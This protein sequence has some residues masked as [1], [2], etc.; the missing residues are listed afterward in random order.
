[1][2]RRNPAML[3]V[4]CALLLVGLVPGAVSG[5]SSQSASLVGKV[6][7][8]SGGA[9][10]GVTVIVKSPQLQ[11][12]QLTAVTGVDGDYRVLE[13]PPGIFS[14]AFELSGFQTQLRSDVHLTV[15]LAGKVDVVMKIG[16]LS[17]TIQVSGQS[18]VV[19]TVNVTGQTTLMQDQLRTI[20]MGGT[21]QEMLPLAAGV[22]MQSKPDVGDSN[23][24]ARSAII[25]YGVVLQPTLDV[26]GI[27]TVTDHAA[28]TAVY[29][30]TFSLE[31]VQFKTSGNNAD[32]G[33]PGVAQV[34]VLK[35]GSNTFHGSARGSY[36]NPKWQGNNIT[37]ALAAQGI[38]NTNPIV[39][40]GFYDDI[41][42]LGG[43]II[44]DK[45]WFY[46]AYSNQAVTQG[47]VGFVLAPN[48]DGC[49]LVTCGGTT[50]ATVHTD[51]PGYS[52]KVSYQLNS[53]TKLI[54]SKMYAVKHLSVN[55]GSPTTPLPSTR[56]QRQPQSAWKG[57]MQSA[58]SA[59]LLFNGIFGY[60]GYHVNYIDQPDFNTVGFPNGTDVK[61]NP[62]SRETS[63]ALNYGPAI[64][65]E[66]RP[67]N[68]YE[69][70]ASVSYIPERTFL[71][72]THQF[73]FGTTNDWENAGTRI[74]QDKVSGN[75]QL[76]FARGVPSQ[77]VVY[78]YPFAT[79]TNNLFSQAVYATDVMAIKRVTLNFGVRWERYHNF[80]P[81]QTRESGQF[82][83]LFPAKTYPK[84][85]VLTWI[86]TVPRAG[87][88][89]DVM[90][91][92]KTVIKGSFGLFG[93]TMGDLYSNAFNPNAAATQT[94]AWTGPCVT[95]EFRNN[96]FNNTSCDVTS[97]FLASLPSRTPIAAT[98]GLNSITNPDLK[99]NKTFEYTARM[100][101]QLIANAAISVGYVYHRVENLYGNLQYLR[102][103]ATWIPA[104]PTTPFLDENGNPVT[105]YTYPASQVGAAFNT[106]QASNA[107][108]DRADTF[109]SFEVAA[110]KRFSKK[111][112]GTTS[113]WT[114]KNHQ[115]I[116]TGTTNGNNPQSP[117]DDR[118]PLIQTWDWEARGNVT[119]NLPLGLFTS[120]SYRAQSGQAGQ[121]TQAFTAPAT[122]LRQGS[123]TL[124]MG[125]FG[126]L[127]APALQILALKVAKTLSVG[128]GRRLELTFQ[129]FNALNASG[130][131]GVNYLT[132]TQFG[133]VTGITSARVARIGAG[134]TF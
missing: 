129:V 63:N 104:V 111:W 75:Y 121:R 124:R 66:D 8:E 126:D 4:G 86:D 74:L 69:M 102:P 22:S 18:P 49:W 39:D 36:E 50:P 108:P 26:E 113:F 40:P 110:T 33:F 41:L 28:D 42:D 82:N 99:Q 30:N 45:L 46:G 119:Y 16:E 90:G 58:P 80:Y 115:W 122:V 131:T 24:A 64:N 87:A 38:T 133:Q 77:I 88:A 106:L 13:L 97:D 132:G 21:M 62:T 125:E 105:I 94:Y 23:L 116:L 20:P 83:V 92:G 25:T 127:R 19:D 31:E 35:S 59:K 134:F 32:I 117:N 34:A 85:D 68:R 65:P 78:N 60:G 11:V 54:A 89:W 67:Q 12:A 123:V 100:E 93:D 120:A 81:E 3:A 101:R 76:Q 98:G 103:Y 55:G 48:A 52:V 112:T 91:N 70:K 44:K 95:T 43:R 84:Q 73:K 96:T 14:I 118:F 9:M 56:F 29:L 57:E 47:Q 7:D 72:G 2:S 10:P 27:N 37:P 6:T 130:V 61:G 114:T 1:M 107:P 17:E 71:G 51:L 5:Q 53:T 128:A 109:H 79:S 15:G